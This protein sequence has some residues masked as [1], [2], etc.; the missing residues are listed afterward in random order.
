MAGMKVMGWH[1]EDG[2]GFD[3]IHIFDWMRHF[4]V[5]KVRDFWLE[6][7]FEDEACEE[8]GAVAF[9]FSGVV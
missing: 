7:T 5:V 4:V 8:I 2:E 9:L 3:T 1:T 6:L